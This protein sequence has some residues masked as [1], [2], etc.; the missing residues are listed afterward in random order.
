LATSG[1]LT[2]AFTYIWASENL[3]TTVI[4][5]ALIGTFGLNFPIFISTMS[6]TVFGMGA[7][8]YGLLTSAMAVGT[9]IGAIV[10]AT[11]QR[12]SIHALTLSAALFGASLAIAAA[13]PNFW[14]FAAML[15][16]IGIPALTFVNVSNSLMQLA[17]APALRGRVVAIRLAV[18]SGSTF[19]G[20]PL[21][22]WIADYVG[23][24]W[25]MASGAVACLAAA[26]IG[27]QK[28]LR[29]A[30]VPPAAEP[31]ETTIVA[32][33]ELPTA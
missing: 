18:V 12:P 29:G 6:V 15:F 14:L 25:A 7:G 27:W 23:P 26:L 8:R 4:M 32:E 28:G 13:M 16:A 24:R 17:A 11:Q 10:A 3:R 30:V 2:E 20:A 33:D 22:G 9:I 5:L 1:N 21:A 19:I 31:G